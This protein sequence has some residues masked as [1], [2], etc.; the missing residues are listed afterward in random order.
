M[1]PFLYL[2]YTIYWGQEIKLKMILHLVDKRKVVIKTTLDIII[3][4]SFNGILFTNFSYR[5]FHN[6]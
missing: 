6:T 3:S 2:N 1:P 5:E 4:Y